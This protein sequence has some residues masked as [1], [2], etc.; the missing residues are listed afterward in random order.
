MLVRVQGE[1]EQQEMT[2]QTKSARK[3]LLGCEKCVNQRYIEAL[4]NA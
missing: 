4:H 2:K 3:G 1:T